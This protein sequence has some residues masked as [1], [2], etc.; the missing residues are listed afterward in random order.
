MSLFEEALPEFFRYCFMNSSKSSVKRS[1]RS[2]FG[3]FSR[4][5]IKNSPGDLFRISREV[6]KEISLEKFSNVL[7][8]IFQGM[9][10]DFFSGV[11]LGISSKNYL[12]I[13][14]GVNLKIV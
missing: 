6:Q 4:S 7:S 8:G 9:Y 2:S 13:P 1:F 14:S 5:S 12:E 3:H 11:L 10:S